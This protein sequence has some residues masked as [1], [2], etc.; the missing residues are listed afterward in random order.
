MSRHSLI[1]LLLACTP[2]RRACNGKEV[3]TYQELWQQVQAKRDKE[4]KQLAEQQEQWSKTHTAFYTCKI[5]SE[6]TLCITKAE[7][8]GNGI[9]VHA[10]TSTGHD[11]MCTDSNTFIIPVYVQ[12]DIYFIH[13]LGKTYKLPHKDLV[14]LL[15]VEG[16]ERKGM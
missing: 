11:N 6:I 14:Y 13:Y 7:A 12:D 8:K 4:A 5:T 3:Y 15:Q 9:Y 2:S 16:D 10:Y 1:N